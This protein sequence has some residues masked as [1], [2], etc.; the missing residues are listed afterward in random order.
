MTAS[1]T[2]RERMVTVGGNRLFVRE[3]GEG[4][5]ILLV[6][7]LGSNA[8]MWGAVESRLATAAR[9]I[10]YDLPGS[11][12]SPTPHR[13]LSIATLA[14]DASDLLDALGYD[15]TDVLGFSLGGLVAQQLAH[16]RS[17]RVRRMALVGTA[18]G[19]GSMPPTRQALALLAM[20]IRYHSRSLYWH[21]N[22][23]LSPGDRQ[24]L[25][26]LP[27]L[28]ESRLRHPP[29]LL[30]YAYQLSAGAM[31]SSLPWIAAV[32]IPSLLLAGL[33][34]H[35]VPAANSVQ[36]A[37]L[38]PESRLH[39]LP[40][41][42]HLF[43]FDPQGPAIPLLESF[44]GSGRHHESRAWSEGMLVDRDELVESAFAAS[45]GFLP[46]RA[47]SDAYRRFVESD[48]RRRRQG[49]RSAAR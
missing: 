16:D 35:V 9:T 21:T 3:Q 41:A 11:G 8:D 31:W 45:H 49:G 14:R 36:L 6:N 34:D 13:P 22:H 42:G 43:V 32:R 47:F 27:N 19:W 29:P 24:L 33:D 48:R 25:S 23:L 44:F 18:C 38:L 20:P 15:R 12:R 30:G 46:H 1:G 17:D 40:G 5:P 2:R 28:T 7:G 39:L 4:T 26:R 10:A 37:R